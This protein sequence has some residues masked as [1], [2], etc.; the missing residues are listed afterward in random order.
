MPRRHHDARREA[1]SRRF[2]R[3]DG[4]RRHR[5]RFSDRLGRRFRRRQ[6]DRQAHQERDRLRACPCR[7]Q[8]YRPLCRSDPAGRA[9]AHPHLPVHLAGAHE[10]QAAEGAARSLRDGDRAGDPRARPYRRRRMVERGRHPHRARFPLPL[11]RGGDQR[12]RHHDQHSRHRRLFGAGGIFCAHQDGARA[13]AEFRPGVLFGALPRRSRHGGGE[14]ARR[15]PRRRPADRVHRQRHRRTRRQRRTGRSRDGD[16][17]AQRRD[18]VLERHQCQDADAGVEA[19]RRGH[20][21]PGAV[22][23]GDRRAECVRAR[24]RHPPGRHAQA[25]AR[26]TRS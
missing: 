14:F 17:G 18:A 8:G 10:I 12:R 1:R 7:V 15:H 3:R 21:V 13:G 24:E 20:L 23:Q 26:P 9:A 22:Q 16:A 6:R 11:R 4:R 19:R 25:H 2:A 5:G